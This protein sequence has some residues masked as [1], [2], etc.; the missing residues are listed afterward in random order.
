MISRLKGIEEFQPRAWLIYKALDD[1]L[2]ERY[3]AC[4]PV[5]LMMIDGFV[6]DLEQKGFFATNIDLTVWDTIAAHDSGL[7][8][9]TTIFGK[10]RTKTTSEEI[11][12]P[13][14]NGILHGR[15]LGYDNRK[16]AAKT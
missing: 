5:V 3:H 7:N 15:D 11:N 13:Y 16:V 4:V 1:Y 14:R 2:A 9:L 6:N 8:T 10:S 12:S